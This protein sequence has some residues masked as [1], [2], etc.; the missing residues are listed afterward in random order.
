[1]LKSAIFN[2]S[3]RL[4]V[5]YR[6][7]P[8]G[9]LVM[10]SVSSISRV[11][12]DSVGFSSSIEFSEVAGQG[13][14]GLGVMDWLWPVLVALLLLLM[15]CL[16]LFLVWRRRRTETELE[17]DGEAD[18]VTADKTVGPD[19]EY[20]HE[21]ENPLF[22]ASDECEISLI[23]ALSLSGVSIEPSCDEGT[24]D[25]EGSEGISDN[26]DNGGSDSHDAELDDSNETFGGGSD[27]SL[28][29]GE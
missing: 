20:T 24:M 26:M 10:T 1:L 19:G 15:G 22:S 23:E 4:S 28:S 6:P 9:A 8:S 17:E 12:A 11:F 3:H 25:G 27:L 16:I 7:S 13:K 29:G 18:F 2:Q 5:S 14:G 21:Y